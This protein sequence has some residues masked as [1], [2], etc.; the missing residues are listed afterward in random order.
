MQD[1]LLHFN[2]CTQGVSIRSNNPC[3]PCDSDPI[4][5]LNIHNSKLPVFI[6]LKNEI[7]S[8]ISRPGY[9]FPFF[10]HNEKQGIMYQFA[11]NK[12]DLIDYT[13]GYCLDSERF[14]DVRFAVEEGLIQ[15]RDDTGDINGYKNIILLR[16]SLLESGGLQL[17]RLRGSDH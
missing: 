10:T 17:S 3:L 4:R 14:V 15:R 13:I 1:V 12:V 8:N 5:F 7:I 2:N 11:P 6:N 9:S 16:H